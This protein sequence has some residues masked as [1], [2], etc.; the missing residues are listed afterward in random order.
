MSVEILTAPAVTFESPFPGLRPFEVGESDRFFGREDDIFE[1]LSRLRH[2]RFLAVVGASGCGKSSLVRAGLIASLAEGALPGRWRVAI[3]RPWQSPVAQLA[4]ALGADVPPG[5]AAGAGGPRR[6]GRVLDIPANSP[7]EAAAIVKAI[8]QKGSLGVVEVLRRYPLP[9]GDN[10]LILVDQ[11]EEL[12]TF[13]RDPKI[14]GAQDEARAFVKLLLEVLCPAKHA[15][16]PV[17]VALVMRSDFLGD[18]ALFPGLAD[19]INNGLYLLPQMER[20]QLRDAIREPVRVCGGQISE[21]LIDTLINDLREDTDQ[22][23]ILQ[24]A[25][26]RLWGVWA[27]RGGE[28]IDFDDYREIGEMST[29]LSNHA[30]EVFG[31]LDARQQQIAEAIFRG[32]TRVE[33]G[34]IV[35]RQTVLGLIRKSAKLKGAGFREVEAVIN[36]FRADGRSF[37]VP[38]PA[39]EL[40]DDT[41]VDIS[42]ES[43]IRQWGRLRAWAEDEA[44]G[45][46]LHRQIAEAARIW[47]GK[48]RD[49]DYLFGGRRLL[50]ADAWSKNNPGVLSG[51]EDEFLV[52]SQNAYEKKILGQPKRELS[53]RVVAEGATQ[54]AAIERGAAHVFLAYARA[55]RAFAERLREAFGEAGEETLVD[56][57]ILPSEEFGDYVRAAVEAADTFVYVISPSSAESDLCRREL[58]HALSRNKRIVPV[59]LRQAEGWRPPEQLRSERWIRFTEKDDFRVAFRTLREAINSDLY[60][61]QAHSRLLVRAAEWEKKGRDASLLLRGRELSGAEQWLGREKS[62]PALTALQRRYILASR[63][64]ATKRQRQ[65]LGVAA[66]GALMLLVL[67]AVAG[68]AAFVAFGER[69]RAQNLTSVAFGERSRAEDEAR[70]ATKALED[71]KKLGQQYRAERLLGR[72]AAE[73]Y[74]D[75]LEI[76][77]SPGPQGKKSDAAMRTEKAIELSKIYDQLGFDRATWRILKS[78][79]KDVEHASFA[80]DRPELVLEVLDQY[81]EELHEQRLDDEAQEV[82]GRIKRFSRGRQRPEAPE[83]PGGK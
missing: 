30:E 82:E 69:S 33:D 64:Y 55:D 78:L 68:V 51:A 12:F 77:D 9:P 37:L 62:E 1:L 38:P 49:E 34:K 19:A 13:M 47:A 56:W 65:L 81:A 74:N 21:R 26:M 2:M 10:L 76:D 6:G 66:A 31:S 70:K 60:W 29:S 22:L 39:H 36:E 5:E 41:A 75:I 35:R 18:C 48:G 28:K 20:E 16:L 24:H 17:H 67:A 61:V 53:E 15:D 32:L 23:P 79:Q 27:R 42:H 72:R 50:E 43:L 59:L 14:G 63:A 45:R 25:V 58:E 44:T 11:F 52:A 4:A 54:V 73:L 71:G 80:K 40:D 83:R 3:L 57:D 46:E 7:G 8:L